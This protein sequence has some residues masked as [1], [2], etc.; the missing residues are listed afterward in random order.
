MLYYALYVPEGS[1]PFPKD[2]VNDPGVAK[3][4]LGWGK[5][6]DAGFVAID[7]TSFLQVGAVWVR[8]FESEN[9][10]YGYVDENIPELSIAILPGFRNKGLGTELLNKMIIEAGTRFCGLSLSVTTENPARRLYERLGFKLVKVN[11]TSLTMLWILVR[12][13]SWRFSL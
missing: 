6:G 8:L 1:S 4:V 13:H 10:G 11:G 3:Y 5:L 7:E 2:I 12:A 9:P